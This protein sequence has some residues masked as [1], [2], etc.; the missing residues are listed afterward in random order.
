MPISGTDKYGESAAPSQSS[1]NTN[2][3]IKHILPETS[4]QSCGLVISATPA[5]PVQKNN[6]NLTCSWFIDSRI[7]KIKVQEASIRVRRFSR[8]T[9]FTYETDLDTTSGV[10]NPV[11]TKHIT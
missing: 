9:M 4:T 6:N 8:L 7:L 2:K 1:A 5:K 3:A 10:P 11:L